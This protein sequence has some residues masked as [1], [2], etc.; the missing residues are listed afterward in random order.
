MKKQLGTH[1]LSPCQIV[2]WKLEKIRSI[3]G[4]SQSEAAAKLTPYLGRHMGRAAISQA[5]RC[6]EKG[7]IHRFDADEI[8]A[9]ARA[10]EVPIPFFFTPA[11]PNRHGKRITVN[12]KPG[13]REAQ[14]SSPPLSLREITLLAQGRPDESTLKIIGEVVAANQ[15]RA[16]SLGV[17]RYLKEHPERLCELSASKIPDDLLEEL[18]EDV[19][20]NRTAHS[21]AM[22]A[23][24]AKD[25]LRQK[26]RRE[27]R[28]S[29]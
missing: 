15:E 13:D 17:Y 18:L 11:E 22:M 5:E 10:F 26:R 14:V 3:R 21:E 7:R 25:V 24:Q 2:A 16:I 12:G 6:L 20:N 23:E 9:Y 28:Y 4:L 29:Y 19:E 1:T 8:V 27:K